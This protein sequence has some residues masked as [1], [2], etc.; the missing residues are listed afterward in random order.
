M[1][2]SNNQEVRGCSKCGGKKNTEKNEKGCTN[3]KKNLMKLI[4]TVTF[5]LIFFSFAVYGVVTFVK[6][7][8]SLFSK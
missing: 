6:D 1:E 5:S 8:I 2:P 7:M 3:C 4:P